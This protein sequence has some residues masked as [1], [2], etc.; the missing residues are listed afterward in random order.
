[1]ALGLGHIALFGIGIGK[2]L[3]ALPV[4]G[5]FALSAG[6]PL[7]LFGGA[8]KPLVYAERFSP[9]RLVLS[10]L[11]LEMFVWFGFLTAVFGHFRRFAE[12]RR[13]ALHNRRQPRF[14]FLRQLLAR[15][16]LRRVY[17]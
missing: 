16:A 4:I 5:S 3:A 6:L 12:K 9:P 7:S 15:P 2:I 17:D 14:W 13:I 1:M 11:G 8:L 10:I